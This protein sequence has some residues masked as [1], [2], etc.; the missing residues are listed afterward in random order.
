MATRNEAS[1]NVCRNF[2]EKRDRKG[3]TP[4][5]HAVRDESLYFI[6]QLLEAGAD[7]NAEDNR[8]HTPIDYCSI[9]IER[10]FQKRMEIMRIL[11][12]YG[13]DF[14]SKDEYGYTNLHHSVEED[15]IAMVEFLLQQ[16]ANINNIDIYGNTPL[17][18]AVGENHMAMVE[19]L[20]QYYPDIIK[21]KKGLTPLDIAEDHDII[22]TLVSY[23]ENQPDIKEPEF[24]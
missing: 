16:G 17:H 23:I 9:S 11:I 5:H 7:I 19:L 12:E 22:E 8:G 6:R 2:V 14:D 3:R 18:I 1:K 10:G 20:L 4:L 24:N 21:N 15:N 13:A